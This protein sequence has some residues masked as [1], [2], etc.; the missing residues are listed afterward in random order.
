MTTARL[1][2]S[3]NLPLKASADY[4]PHEVKRKKAKGESKKEK[5]RSSSS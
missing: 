1:P 2:A 3:F 5:L 4:N